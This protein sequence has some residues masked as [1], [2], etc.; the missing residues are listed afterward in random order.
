MK[1]ICCVLLAVLAAAGMLLLA[2]CT[3]GGE[4]PGLFAEKSLLT[5]AEAVTLVKDLIPK[6]LTIHLDV[7]S[8][9]EGGAL[10]VDRSVFL[11]GTER[12]ENGQYALV[13]GDKIKSVADLKTWV[14]ETLTPEAAGELYYNRYLQ[15]PDQPLRVLD[16]DFD[17]GADSLPQYYDYEG[18]LYKHLTGGKGYALIWE[19]D[20]VKII[21]LKENAVTAEIEVSVFDD[22]E[23]H[24]V[25]L[26]RRDSRW[27]IANDIHGEYRTKTLAEDEVKAIIR[28]LIPQAVNF[29]HAVFGGGGGLPLDRET[30]LP[31]TEKIPNGQYV[32][33]ADDKIKSV[34]ALRVWIEKTY[35]PEM[36]NTLFY[37]R[38]LLDQ[39]KPLRVLDP[40]YDAANDRVPHYYDY[41]G[42]LYALAVG[43]KGYEW[44][45]QY[46]TIQITEISAEAAT[47][48]IEATCWDDDYIHTV[49]LLKRYGVWL[50]AND[51]ENEFVE[52]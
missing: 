22:T 25:R 26:E 10:K 19:Y 17:P 51:F 31:G 4:E 6:A 8:G 38:Y 41:E 28:E 18:K 9:A 49:K 43:G 48:K 23:I 15:D 40:E 13:T 32:L 39:D 12:I 44:E 45:Y 35:T 11:P 3:G 50:L 27:L 47:A 20:R 52:K 24:I 14:E 1:K 2:G 5:E 36:A 37:D 34:A 42:N 30:F 46:D 16:P 21:D 33:V 29:S 7:F